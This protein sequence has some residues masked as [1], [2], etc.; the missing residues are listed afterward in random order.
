[1]IEIAPGAR[2]SSLADIEDSL[3]GSRIRIGAGTV[4]D[5]FVKI[6][7]A[8]GSGDIEIGPG[9]VINSGCVLYTGNGIRIG[10]NVLIAANCTLAPTSHEF[11]DRGRP[12]CEQGFRPSRGG[13]V[14]GDDVWIGANAVL[15]DGARI[16][17]GSVIG[18][19]SL[20]RSL[21]PAFCIAVGA[22][23]RVRGWR[24]RA[25]A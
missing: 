2:V 16:G 13:I 18:A 9:C 3:R 14:I 8:G 21:L 7:P 15:L 20:V 10:A 6:K 17:A 19:G 1:M 4:I 24:G 11:A 12:I 22:P 5:A 23:A 25:A